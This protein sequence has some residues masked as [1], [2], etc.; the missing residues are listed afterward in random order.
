V[1]AEQARQL[2]VADKVIGADDKQS[3]RAAKLQSRIDA[4][5]D[6]ATKT[7]AQAAYNDLKSKL[8]DAVTKAQAIAASDEKLDITDTS[9]ARATL[10]HNKS[11]AVAGVKADRQAVKSD[12]QRLRKDLKGSA[13]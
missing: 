8:D 5:P 6:G 11:T 4:L 10:E 2:G 1:L 12:I 13:H 7:D 3:G 9:A